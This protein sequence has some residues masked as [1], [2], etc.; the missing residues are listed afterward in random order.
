MERYIR[1]LVLG[2]LHLEHN[3]VQGPLAGF[4]C[5]PFRELIWQFGSVGYCTTEMLSAKD[6]ITRKV[7]R[8]RYV[9][10]SPKE[11]L[12]C[13]QLSGNDSQVVAQAA[14]YAQRLGAD[15]IDLNCG[16]PKKKIRMK[17]T[18]SRLLAN[19]ALLGEIV[20]AM[21]ASTELPLSV[22]IRV[23]GNSADKF[24]LPVAKTIEAAGAD[25]IIVHGRH[26]TDDYSVSCFYEQ[27]AQIVESV[28]IPVLANGD[29]NDYA[30]LQDMFMKTGAAGVMISRGSMGQPWLFQRLVAEDRGEHFQ[31]PSAS[32]VGRL[33]I[34]HVERLASLEDEMSALLQARKFGKYY[35]R[36]I[37]AP[38]EFFKHLVQTSKIDQLSCLVDDFFVDCSADFLTS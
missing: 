23:D 16:C 35:G 21:R 29:V 36:S 5:A 12:L 33:L 8:P 9:C 25:F 18:G 20:A 3:I 7:Q 32:V 24:N 28:S 30:S 6:L 13:Y 38:D 15:L 1:S 4:S 22:K 14:Q 19:T 26:W 2:Q 34:Q 17:G 27:I 11:G 10:K 37:K 31:F